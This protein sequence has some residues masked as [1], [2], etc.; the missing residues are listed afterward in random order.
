AVRALAADGYRVFIEVSPHAVLTGAVTETAGDAG[1]A[2]FAV[3]AA[4][5]L[6]RV[7]VRGVTVDWAAVL[8]GGRR[9]ELP[10]YPFQRQRFWPQARPAAVRAAGDGAPDEG[11]RYRASWMPVPD[12]DRAALSGTWLVVTPAGESPGPARALA[13]DCL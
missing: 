12:P 13:A 4:G 2:G 11:C 1:E 9:V 7:H 5:T 10:T 3:V 8:A 6:D